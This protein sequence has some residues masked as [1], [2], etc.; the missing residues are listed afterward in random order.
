MFKSKPSAR[1]LSGATR[2]KPEIYV[3]LCRSVL[4]V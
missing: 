3:L 1:K 2:K 4:M